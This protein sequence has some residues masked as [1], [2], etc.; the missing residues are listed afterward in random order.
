MAVRHGRDPMLYLYE[1]FL[2]VFDPS[3]VAKYGV[4]YTPPEVVKLMVAQ[5][6]CELINGLGT[7]GLLD[8]NVRLLDPACGTGTFMIGAADRAADQAEAQFGG[9]MVGANHVRFRAA[10]VWV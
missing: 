4:Y 6:E 10:H 7:N 9:G 5:T 3:A 2:R 8:P 1:D